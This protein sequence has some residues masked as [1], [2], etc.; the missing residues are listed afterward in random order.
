MRLPAMLTSALL[1]FLATPSWL[2]GPGP[3]HAASEEESRIAWEEGAVRITRN[4]HFRQSVAALYE[5][6]TVAADIDAKY[7]SMGAR[8]IEILEIASDGDQ[9][10]IRTRREVPAKAPR[11]LRAF[12]RDWTTV[13][14]DEEWRIEGDRRV[15]SVVVDIRGVPVDVRGNVAI[16]PALDGSALDVDLSVRCRIPF[17]GR[18]LAEFVAQNTG[19]LL[20]LQAE[21]LRKRLLVASSD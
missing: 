17:L 4:S 20:D 10:R 7:R 1:V 9:L 14:Q 19:E 13:E 8:N 6:F 2:S 5:P 21:F 16:R 11:L 12:V 15:A 3:A 18:R